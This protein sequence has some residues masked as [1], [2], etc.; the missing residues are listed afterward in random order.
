[1][2][3][4]QEIKE[5]KEHLEKAQNPL[6][7]FD[8]DVD[9]LCSYLLLRRAIGRGMG[10]AVKSFPFLDA[11]YARKAKELRA[12]YVFILDKPVVSS[13]F[14]KEIKEMN[15]QVVWIDHH[16]VAFP[17][18][19]DFENVSYYN[20]MK[21]DNPTNEPVT[22]WAYKIVEKREDLWLALCGCIGDGY[23]PDFKKEAEEI[24]PEYWKPVKSAFEGLYDTE[25]GRIAQ[26]LNFS[27]KDRTSNV[28]KMLKF[29]YKA[30]LSDVL[31]EERKG[32]VLARF[33]QIYGKYIKLVEK[34]EDFV[35]NDDVLYF[36]YGGD[37][38]ISADIANEIFYNHSDKI[39]IV[40]YIKGTKANISIRGK[41]NV[42]DLTLKSI[43]GIEHA[44]GGGHKNAT[45]AQMNVEDL[46]RFLENFKKIVR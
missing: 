1:M 38:S 31:E 21:S 12:D 44:T 7:Y 19:E 4:E 41:C 27:L 9:G 28:V 5:I 26:I 11:S 10:V 14:L 32:G 33:N 20:T 18:L 29:M 36:K 8:N 39:V 6:F 23:L 15:L 42:R 13:D 37:L 40:A 45:G 35:T 16:E 22:Y 2:L 24:Y 30:G 34:A 46:P 3:T 25:L 43:E 17:E